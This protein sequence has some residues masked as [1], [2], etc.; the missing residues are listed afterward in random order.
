MGGQSLRILLV[1]GRLAEPL[2]R[3]YGGEGCDVFV[4]PVSVAAFLT[5]PGLIARYLKKAGGVKSDDYDLV[6]IPGLVRGGSAQ[7]IEDELGIPTFKGGRGTR[8]TS[9]RRS[10]Q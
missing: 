8:W 4:T 10:G 1:T 7:I 6:L 5:P 2:V 3:K 9:R